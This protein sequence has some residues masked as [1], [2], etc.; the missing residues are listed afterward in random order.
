MI[1]HSRKLHNFHFQGYNVT[2]NKSVMVAETLSTNGRD[3]HCLSNSNLKY[4]KN[5]TF[6]RPAVGTRF[7]LC[8]ILKNSKNLAA[9]I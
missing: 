3:E 6:G 7:K 4:Q 8:R 9:Q 1:L 2:V 5:L